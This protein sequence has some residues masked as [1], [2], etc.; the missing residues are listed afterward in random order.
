MMR[1]TPPPEPA[2]F[3]QQVRKAGNNWLV[4]NPGKE[5]KDLWSTFKSELASE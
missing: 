1:F 4:N 2:D 5:P 3:E